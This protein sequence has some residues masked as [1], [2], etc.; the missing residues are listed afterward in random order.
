MAGWD[1]RMF[2]NLLGWIE[3]RWAQPTLR[4]GLI[5]DRCPRNVDVQKSTIRKLLCIL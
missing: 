4:L 5:S 1:L 2:K 3:G